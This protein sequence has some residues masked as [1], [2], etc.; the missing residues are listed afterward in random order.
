MN[1]SYSRR[2]ICGACLLVPF[3]ASIAQEDGVG[4]L[5][6]G[7]YGHIEHLIDEESDYIE[8]CVLQP[9]GKII[10]GAS[11]SSFYQ[12]NS[13]VKMVRFNADGSKDLTYSADGIAE[14]NFCTS[15]DNLKDLA[16]QPDGKLVGCG[17]EYFSGGS[18]QAVVFRMN[19]NGTVDTGFGNF[20]NGFA[21]FLVPGHDQAKACGSVCKRMAGSTASLPTGPGP[22]GRRSSS[23]TRR[24]GNWT[25]RSGTT[26]YNPV[27]T[28]T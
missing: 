28:P 18:G 24:R 17:Y 1:M 11:Q 7:N 19:G 23:A 5:G 27:R 9:D 6:F 21:Y 26:A 15:D 22:L 25:P 3:A 2:L 12:D 10:V 4:D 13:T 14:I 8:A 16:L 20:G